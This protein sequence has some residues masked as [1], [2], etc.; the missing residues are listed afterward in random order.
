MTR[1]PR[2]PTALDLLALVIAVPL[3]VVALLV[4]LVL[5]PF[6]A[7]HEFA[8]RVAIHLVWVAKGKRILL[9]YTR[10]PVWFEYIESTWLPRIGDHTVTLNLSDQNA[11]RRSKSLAARAYRHWKPRTN[12]N[13]M[14]IMFPRF[15]R[16]QRL[17]FYDA[18][19]DLK[20][21]NEATLRTAEARLFEFADG[22]GRPG[23]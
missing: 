9:V 4:L 11:W 8:L 17:G 7:L 6:M 5:S 2:K 19:Q 1:K 15:L 20:H 23:A 22:L 12:N 13:P 14:V 21:G 10:S 18:F 16:T 3:L